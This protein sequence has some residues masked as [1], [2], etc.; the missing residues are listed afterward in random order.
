MP[1]EF[2]GDSSEYE[3]SLRLPSSN[4]LVDISIEKI[5]FE[6]EYYSEEGEK[7]SV[8]ESCSVIGYEFPEYKVDSI[9]KVEDEGYEI[10]EIPERVQDIVRS[11]EEFQIY[12]GVVGNIRFSKEDYYR[13]DGCVSMT[14]FSNY[15]P[16][17]AE[18][19]EITALRLDEFIV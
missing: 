11:I 13:I 1:I 2:N 19:A 7:K 6:E 4:V 3:E 12:R 8:S 18:Y 9:V 14:M 5:S 17:I 15:K 16:D 10:P